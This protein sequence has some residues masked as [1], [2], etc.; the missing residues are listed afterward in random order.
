M[1]PHVLDLRPVTERSATQLGLVTGDQL[2]ALGVS[3]QARRTLAARGA[4]ER[5]GATVWR[6]PGHPPSLHQALLAAVLEAGPDA[7]VSHMSACAWWRFAGIRPGAVEVSVPRPVQ[8]GRRVN[9]LVHR[10]RDLR[11]VDVDARGV[12]PV[13]TPARSLIDAAPRLTRAQIVDVLD[14]ATRDGLI[15]LAH[16]RWRLDELRRRGR[17]GI[18]RMLDALPADD[19]PRRRE[20]SWL[21]RRLTRLIVAAGL[22]APRCQVRLRHSGGVARVDMCYERSRLVIET[23]GH[24]SHATRRGRQSDAERDARLG[25]AGYRVLRFT[26]DDVVGRPDHVVGIIR[27]YLALDAAAG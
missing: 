12:V 25:A 27:T 17:P 11:P 16:L 3:R 1:A 22:P 19:E 5:L 23:D 18:R 7:A 10:A 20:E 24:G 21:E 4:L 26:Y 9:G 6:L 8:R 13:T 14:G 2:A 15:D